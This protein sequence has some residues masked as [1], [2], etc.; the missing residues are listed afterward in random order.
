M[1]PDFALSLSF[2]GIKLMCRV[3]E[4][5]HLLGE[6]PLEHADL[7]GALTALR[8]KGEDHAGGDA[9]CKIILPNDQ[10]K[11]LS[12]PPASDDVEAAVKAALEDATPY[13]IDELA[14]DYI[15]SD[16]GIS[17]AAV[18]R[19]T[20]GEAEEFA[21]E[22]GF[23]P[24]CF[25]AVPDDEAFIGEPF[26]GPTKAAPE[27]VDAPDALGPD[28]LAVAV[29]SEGPVPATKPSEPPPPFA[30]SR[31]LS[32][33]EMADGSAKLPGARRALEGAGEVSDAQAPSQVSQQET[34][35][36][37]A[38]LI[39]GMKP[40]PET[41]NITRVRGAARVQTVDAVEV[42]IDPQPTEIKEQPK[43]S[44][45]EAPPTRGKPKYLGVILVALLLLFLAGVAIWASLTSESSVAG[46]FSST[47]DTSETAAL[48]DSSQE[49]AIEPLAPTSPETI[50]DS[51][52]IEALDGNEGILLDPVL[53]AAE[54][55]LSGEAFYAATGIWDRAPVQPTSPGS[56]E[57]DGIYVGS[58]ETTQAT[59]DA[60]A[61][62]SAESY[63]LDLT[64]DSQNDPVPADIKIT[65][66]ERGL[67]VA[68]A[69][70][71]I[72][73]EGVLVYL[74]KPA[75][76]PASIPVRA[77]NVETVEAPVVTVPNPEFAQFRPRLRPSDL[78]EQN[79]RVTLGGSTLSEI[80]KIRP[81]VRPERDVQIASIDPDAIRAAT[82]DAVRSATDQAVLSSLKP[83]V[84]PKDFSKTVEKTQERLASVAVPSTQRLAPS[85]PTTASVARNATQ[86]NAINLRKINLIGV[87]GSNSNRR[88]L[89]RMSN[90][91]YKKVKVGDRIDG[92]KIAAIGSNELRYVKN[93]RSLVLKMPK[94]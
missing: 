70:G 94:G 5:W 30:T 22:H 62:P 31:S 15:E 87:Y 39:A 68:T 57:A 69:E 80:A 34:R 9:L 85:I 40:R 33:E 10:I 19:E 3:Q 78:T 66:D 49:L 46:F 92:G 90:G 7:E 23:H 88:A 75:T 55:Q 79:Q 60:I 73:P 67:V 13:Q 51:A 36:D 2:D 44:T 37:P 77:E 72:S 86:D 89:V 82:D 32:A 53:E 38:T 91:R 35:F 43:A 81:R 4:G 76:V 12:L 18:A 52:E 64:I 20:L 54:P 61:L 83:R 65:L 63:G 56:E 42:E 17:V 58:F 84:R 24:I 25:V 74:G 59:H 29:V 93:K 50:T 6:V 21:A 28:D 47:D 11:Y 26:F 27:L 48:T 45:P 8:K 16:A 41:P 14:F 1:K 71:A